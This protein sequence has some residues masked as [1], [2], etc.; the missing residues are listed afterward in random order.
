MRVY[1]CG[2][3]DDY[4]ESELGT[5]RK[6]AKEYLRGRGITCLDPTDRPYRNADYKEDPESVL[7][8]LVEADKID[9][10]ASDVLLVNYTKISVGTS[11]E[12]L[13]AWQKGK[14]VI[15]VSPEGMCLGAWIWYHSH[16]RFHTME[17]AY[18]HIVQVNT[19][20]Y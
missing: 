13:I 12:I 14:Q 4:T 9:I 8:D 10:E 5:W 15:V 1:L 6:D 20:N 2:P 11:M 19:R 17:E 18:D 7:P 16:K 3:M